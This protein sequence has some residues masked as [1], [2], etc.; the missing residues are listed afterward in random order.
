MCDTFWCSCE[1]CTVMETARESFCCQETLPVDTPGAKV[2]KK[3][4]EIEGEM[5]ALI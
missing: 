5:L 2:I 3:K 4:L 1:H